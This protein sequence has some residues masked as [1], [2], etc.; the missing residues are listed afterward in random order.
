MSS[1]NLT[2][3]FLVISSFVGPKPPV[4]ITMSE[5]SMEEF[6]VFRISDSLSIIEE[7]LF[8]DKPIL[9]NSLAIKAEFVSIV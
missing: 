3:V 1:K 7:I 9:L 8:T 5:L 2:I 4:T 6:K